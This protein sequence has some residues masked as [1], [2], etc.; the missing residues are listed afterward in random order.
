MIKN[1]YDYNETIMSEYTDYF[2]EAIVANIQQEYRNDVNIKMTE[3]AFIIHR[4][5]EIA[6]KIVRDTYEDGN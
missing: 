1:T 4:L 3:D 2:L 6:R 5:H